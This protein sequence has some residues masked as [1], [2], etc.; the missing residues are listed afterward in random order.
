MEIVVLSGKGGTGKTSITAA[1]AT[2]EK[3]IVLADCDVDAANMHLVME[4]ENYIEE[5]F[6]A[7]AK[8]QVNNDLCSLCGK[9]IDYCRFD[10]ISLIDNKIIIS[11]TACDGC[12]L[13]EKVCPE[14]AISM[15]ENDKSR[16]FVGNFRNGKMIHGR[17]APGEDNSGKLVALVK[18]KARE[19]Q[20]ETNSDIFLIDGP[21][22]IGCPVTA[23]V[24]GVDKVILVTEPTISGISDL[25]RI[26]KFLKD[27]KGKIFIIINKFDINEVYSKKIVDLAAKNEIKILGEIPHDTI[28]TEAMINCQAITE[29]KPESKI[30]LEI[31]KIWKQIV[32]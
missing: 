22:G 30:S 14:K 10:A 5:K 19:I 17:L 31:N 24:A 3:K 23:S 21:P 11:E 26:I 25:E 15:Y 16:L 2:L 13:C 29:Y 12:K 18:K 27:F 7:G 1:F 8:A 9:C 4:P 28:F 32:N 20:K 6:I